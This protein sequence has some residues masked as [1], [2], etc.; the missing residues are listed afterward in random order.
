MSKTIKR[1]LSYS[2]FLLIFSFI[3]A[4]QINTK[5]VSPTT[6]LNGSS[7]YVNNRKE[8]NQLQYNVLQYTDISYAKAGRNPQGVSNCTSAAAGSAGGGGCVLDDYYPQQVNVLEIP[9]ST[10]VRIVPWS[11]MSQANWNLATVKNMAANYEQLNPGYRVI[12]AIN[13]DFFDINSN[14]LFPKTPS[15]AHVSN[16]E[17]Y[18]S[19]GS[20]IVSFTNDGST[21]TLIGNTASTRT[22]TPI[23]AIYDANGEIIHEYPVNKV[24]STPADGQ[25]ALYYANWALE[26]GWSGQK[27]VPIDVEDAIIVKGAKYS[28]PISK[29]DFYGIGKI[30]H[31]GTM[32]IGTGDFAIVS[33]NAE[34]TALLQKD[35]QIRV[36][37]EF[38]GVYAGATD[39]I[40]VGDTLLYNNLYAGSTDANRHPRTM[41]GMKEDGTIVM[42]VVDGRQPNKNM[43]GATASEM[44]AILKHYGCKDGYNLDGGGSSTMVILDDGEFRVLNS[45]SDGGERSDS[46][47]LLIVAKIPDITYSASVE[48][49]K[50]TINADL[51]D[52]KGIEFSDLFVE[53]NGVKTKVENGKAVFTNLT[54]DTPYGYKFYGYLDGIYRDLVIE[55]KT[56]TSKRMPELTKIFLARD[57]V[58]LYVYVSI[59]DL[60]NAIIRRSVEAGNRNIIIT[61]GKAVFE[62][63]AGNPLN[64]I[65]INLS[66]DLNDGAGRIDLLLKNQPLSCPISM[67]VDTISYQINESLKDF[68]SK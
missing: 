5:A 14:N 36:Q 39:V 59:T 24:N 32:Q 26:A 18:K 38:S 30:S 12:A 63:F 15:G 9:S 50:I 67:V 34:I 20:R 42:T 40:G 27:L 44:A 28:L 48:I 56:A 49:D 52:Q 68:F 33:K 1:I 19:T 47:C 2:L 35:V 41:V 10:D 62:N 25:I 31:F 43:Y 23:L 65:T 17:Y 55:G 29:S 37:Y 51:V 6:E 16:G 60:D 4:G 8:T 11:K 22:S 58:D 57:G 46:N 21:S 13:G 66:Y 61:K 7:Y 45:P 64:D 3:F 53:L 54:P